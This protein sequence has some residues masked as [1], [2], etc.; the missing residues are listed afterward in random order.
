MLTLKFLK[1]NV[2][3]GQAWYIDRMK[4][5]KY[6]INEKG[7]C[8]GMC[9][10]II[11]A[12]LAEDIFTFQLRIKLL[13]DIPIDY[14]E[15]DFLK[16]RNIQR[17]LMAEGHLAD[18]LS[19]QRNIVDILALFDTIAL[20]QKPSQ[21]KH[22]LPSQEDSDAFSQKKRVFAFLMEPVAFDNTAMQ[23][24]QVHSQVIGGY[25]RRELVDYLTLLQ[26]HLGMHSFS[27]H[28]SCDFHAISLNYDAKIKRWFYADP[29]DLPIKEYANLVA[30]V[31]QFFQNQEVNVMIGTSIWTQKKHLEEMHND[32][33]RMKKSVTYMRLHRPEKAMNGYADYRNGFRMDILTIHGYPPTN[34]MMCELCVDEKIERLQHYVAYG[35]VPSNDMLDAAIEMHQFKTMDFLITQGFTPTHDDLLAIV[36]EGDLVITAF[37]LDKKIEFSQEHLE[38]AC[39]SNNL[40]MT[41][42]L[43]DHH[44]MPTEYILAIACLRN[45]IEI[46]SLLIQNGVSPTSHMLERAIENGYDLII[47]MIKYTGVRTSITFEPSVLKIFNE[48]SE[49]LLS[50]ACS[51]GDLVLAEWLIHQ[52]ISPTIQMLRKACVSVNISTAYFL[53]D[54]GIIPTKKM[55]GIVCAYYY[56]TSSKK[57]THEVNRWFSF[58]NRLIRLTDFSDTEKL[59]EEEQAGIEKYMRQLLK[60]NELSLIKTLAQKGAPLTKAMLMASLYEEVLD[61]ADCFIRQGLQPT[62]EM[63]DWCCHHHKFS[64]LRLLMTH[65]MKPDEKILHKMCATDNVVAV[66]FLLQVGVSPHLDTITFIQTEGSR[67]LKTLLSEQT[68]YPTPPIS[69]ETQT[70]YP[71]NRTRIHL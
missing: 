31:E 37:L 36:D 15:N 22:L 71:Y 18:A 51:R 28:L 64:S 25:N 10:T 42:L 14:F 54:H 20:Y 17:I 45:N 19:I 16:L 39:L 70:F 4:V 53:M 62:E 24:R 1:A 30:M 26:L 12:F 2:M 67:L 56:A 27:I 68:D 7:M 43:I 38:V 59:F 5:L 50:R 57:K 29:S 69:Q 58:I 35:I 3:L 66:Q 41:Q 52:G 46:V 23:A 32:F 6:G 13:Q 11:N 65:G 55:L 61:V 9:F 47:D 21:Y 44:V 8:Y 63:F 33:L 40:A 34:K 48:P 60:L 49:E